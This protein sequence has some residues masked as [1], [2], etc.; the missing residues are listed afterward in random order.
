LTYFSERKGYIFVFLLRI[1]KK[2]DFLTEGKWA[3]DMFH[4][5]VNEKADIFC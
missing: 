1:K 2:D 3:A 5:K 4:Q